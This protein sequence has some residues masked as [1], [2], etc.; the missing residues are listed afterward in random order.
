MI[1]A[2]LVHLIE[3]HGE[4]IVNRVAAQLAS[5]PEMS[6]VGAVLGSELAEWRQDFLRN[7]GHWLTRGQDEVIARHYQQIGKQRCEQGIPLYQCVHGLCL[8]RQ[9]MLDFVEEQILMKDTM[10]L[11]AEEELDRRVGR[12]FDL[13]L[14]NQVRGYEKALRVAKA[15]AYDRGR[16]TTA[17]A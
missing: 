3:N 2:K 10:E 1:T 7:F 11:Y 16:P 9:K 8:L 14:V 4:A 5:E 17:F 6:H 13:L 12:F 15:A